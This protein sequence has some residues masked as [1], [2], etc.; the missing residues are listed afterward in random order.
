MAR[1]TRLFVLDRVRGLTRRLLRSVVLTGILVAQP[2][3]G[4]EADTTVLVRLV[5][6]SSIV[7]YDAGGE[8][9]RVLYSTDT[10]IRSVGVSPDGRYVAFRE[11][12]VREHFAPYRLVVIDPSG[13]VVR[14]VEKDVQVL[15]WCC[16]PGKIA[17]ITGRDVDSHPGFLP[18]RDG[19]FVIDVRTGSET[20]LRGIPFP[21]Q[22]HWAA[23]DSSLYIKTSWTP[24]DPTTVYRYH[25]PTGELSRTSRRGIYFS[26]DGKYYFND[27]VA[28]SFELYRSADDADVR[29]RLPEEVRG[30]LHP[31]WAPDADH[32]LLL[33]IVYHTP[34]PREQR[35]PPAQMVEFAEK[36]A[37]Q[38]LYIVDAETG[39]LLR[40]LDTGFARWSTNA[41]AIVVREDERARWIRASGP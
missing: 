8:A 22:L 25:A 14:I 4:Q 23:F 26:P 6:F 31:M 40:M 3:A 29:S 39:R 7:A 37:R 16:G 13:R 17:V 15:T 28:G 12:T 1:T 20:T 5:A 2:S 21:Y 35:P 24:E 30:V 10:Y 36:I 38:K 18:D 11:L 32:V 19:V 41:K 33:P 9:Q 34:V 27:L